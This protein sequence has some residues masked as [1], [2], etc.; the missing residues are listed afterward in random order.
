MHQ[1]WL[2]FDR[3]RLLVKAPDRHDVRGAVSQWQR[4][5]R[6][7][8]AAPTVLLALSVHL[9]FA[10][11]AAAVDPIFTGFFGSTALRGYDAVAYFSEGRAV[12]GLRDFSTE[13]MG[14]TWRF[15]TLEHLERF[16]TE[17]EKYAPQYGGYCAYAMA[18][19]DTVSSDPKAWS[20]VD[21]KLYVNYSAPVKRN[22]DRNAMMY[23]EQADT[24]WPRLRDAN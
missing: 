14:A 13:W 20:I 23:I 3:K 17:P 15:S 1:R 8:R 22:W 12:P 11:P 2:R 6:G 19:G 16:D 24:H 5:H 9:L 10:V 18:R 21:G 4:A 7:R